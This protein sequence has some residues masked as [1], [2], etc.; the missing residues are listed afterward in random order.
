VRHGSIRQP[1]V[2]VVRDDEEV[3]PQRH[4]AER[5]E[6]VGA[7]G[8]PGGVARTVDDD[9]DGPRPDGALELRPRHEEPALRR[10]FH[11]ARDR[12]RQQQHL[13]VAHPVRRRQDDLVALVEERLERGVERMLAADVRHHLGA[14]VGEGVVARELLHDRVL[15]RVGASD[16]RVLRHAAVERV[17]R[18]RL[19]VLWGVE[20]GLARRQVDHVTALLAEGRR[21]G[22]HGERR[23]WLHDGE[24]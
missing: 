15:Q 22:G 4:L 9:G 14:L 16:R 19:D 6:L 10:G 23:R 2:D 12:A 7:V 1:L 17:A 11:D 21:L 5:A 18:R 24:S 8:G 20:V 3:A 13:G